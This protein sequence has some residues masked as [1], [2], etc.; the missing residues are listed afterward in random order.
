MSLR[1][2]LIAIVLGLSSLGM[3]YTL[4]DLRFGGDGKAEIQFGIRNAENSAP[5][6]KVEGNVVDIQFLGAEIAREWTQRE[7]N[8]PHTLVQSAVVSKIEPNA[9]RVRFVISGSTEDLKK[10]VRLEK[11]DKAVKLLVDY[12]PGASAAATDKSTASLWRESEE[13]PLGTL[14]GKHEKSRSGGTLP[15]I[16]VGLFLTLVTVGVGVWSYRTFKQKGGKVGSRKYL[17]ETVAYHSLGNRNGVSLLKVGDEFV[18]VGITPT[19]V[20]ML[21]HLPGMQKRYA[22]ESQFEREGFQVAVEEELGRIQGNNRKPRV[23]V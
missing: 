10:R 5:Q 6:I 18:L 16:L 13:T 1:P 21:S 23:S 7:W 11:N 19:Q 20:S 12:A 4:E 2:I 17:I 3:A 15:V 14:D 22:E 8:R 9:V